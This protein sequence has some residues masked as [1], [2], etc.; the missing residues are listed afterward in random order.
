MLVLTRKENE[1]IQIGD[2]VVITVLQVK[3][4]SVRIGIEAP[5][6]V[7]HRLHTG[8]TPIIGGARA[9]GVAHSG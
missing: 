4:Q 6:D 7:L 8:L 3:G 2:Q 5:R 1:Q 9:T